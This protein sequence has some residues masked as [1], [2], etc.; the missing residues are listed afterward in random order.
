MLLMKIL[1][2][3]LFKVEMDHFQTHIMI[4]MM[5]LKGHMNYKLHIFPLKL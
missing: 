1:T 2:L 3:V 5:L 4:Y